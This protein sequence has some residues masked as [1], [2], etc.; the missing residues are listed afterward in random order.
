LQV[1]RKKKDIKILHLENIYV[2]IVYKERGEIMGL[3]S[4]SKPKESEWVEWHPSAQAGTIKRVDYNEKTN[5]IKSGVTWSA[6]YDFA[7]FQNIL[8]CIDEMGRQFKNLS[9]K[10]DKLIDDNQEL[11]ERCEL[12]EKE[13]EIK[14]R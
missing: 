11:K 13:A 7:N 1:L 10:M 6:A 12:L 8:F 14:K 5:N 2:I 3:F 4:K 9:D